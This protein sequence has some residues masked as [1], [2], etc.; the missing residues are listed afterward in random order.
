MKKNELVKV[1]ETRCP[2]CGK[3]LT[4]ERGFFWLH[5]DITCS[6]CNNHFKVEH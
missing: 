5:E 1:I 4:E 2:A 3:Y 6:Q